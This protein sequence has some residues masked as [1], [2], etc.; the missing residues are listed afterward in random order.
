MFRPVRLQ[1][2][3]LE[4]SGLRPPRLCDDVAKQFVRDLAVLPVEWS[5]L[6]PAAESTCEFLVV[7]E[8][9]DAVLGAVGEGDVECCEGDG[10]AGHPADALEGEDL[11]CVVTERLVL[12]W[13]CEC[14]RVC[15]RRGVRRTKEYFPERLSVLISVGTAMVRC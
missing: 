11:V 2:L 6:G 5:R 14:W 13:E 12:S 10:L 1:E 3:M 8:G 9:L 15:R 4:V 7:D